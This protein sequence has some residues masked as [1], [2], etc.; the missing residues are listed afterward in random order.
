METW[1]L[2]YKQFIQFIK[3]FW[4]YQ[5]K[6]ILLIRNNN[7]D[8]DLTTSIRDTTDGLFG[9][10]NLIENRLN[11]RFTVLI[12][13]YWLM[14]IIDWRRIHQ[15]LNSKDWMFP[16]RTEKWDFMI[17]VYWMRFSRNSIQ[18]IDSISELLRSTCLSL[19]FYQ[20]L[21]MFCQV[22]IN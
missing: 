11:P 6:K 12:L 4:L 13:D 18:I 19:I 8:D 7:F 15:P 21:E 17:C 5:K 14:E 2:C 1:R 3:T 22:D 9:R 10:L 20:T 16:N